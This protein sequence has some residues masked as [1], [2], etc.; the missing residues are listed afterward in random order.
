MRFG[1]WQ[2]QRHIQSFFTAALVVAGPVLAVATYIVVGPLSQGASSPPLRLILLSDLVYV[3]IV[4]A[5]VMRQVARMVAARRA[6]SAGSRLHLRLTGVFALSALIPTVL[7]AVFSVLLI[8]VAL[9]GLFSE[10]VGNVL[11]TSLTTAQAYEEEHRQELTR[12]A[13]GLAG[14]LNRER[15][16]NLFMDDGEVRRALGDVQPQ[17]D[18]CDNVQMSVHRRAGSQTCIK[19]TSQGRTSR[20][21]ES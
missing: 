13:R 5:V 14:Y 10:P 16:A 20:C 18:R 7:V 6:K 4:M 2:R 9:E 21:G 17:I 12:D 3:L 1:R 11:R 8:S 19:L 15:Q